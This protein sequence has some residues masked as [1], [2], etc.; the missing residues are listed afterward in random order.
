MPLL[1]HRYDDYKVILEDEYGFTYEEYVIAKDVEHAAWTA[2]ELS[3]DQNLTLK[4]I[5]REDEW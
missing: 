3:H 1:G 4:N 2:L 5:I